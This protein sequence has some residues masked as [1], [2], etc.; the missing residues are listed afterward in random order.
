[1]TL[2]GASGA[3]KPIEVLARVG[4]FLEHIFTGKAPA[5]R[6]I[7]KEIIGKGSRYLFE[8]VL[9]LLFFCHFFRKLFLLFLG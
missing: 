3:M 8:E 2:L 7:S 5:V 4:R 6:V 1:M 9:L